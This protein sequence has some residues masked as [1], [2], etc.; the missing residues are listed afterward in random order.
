MASRKLVR[1]L[2]LSRQPLFL[3]L[4]SKQVIFQRKPLSLSP[5]FFVFLY[6]GSDCMF[7]FWR[8]R[9][10]AADYRW[11]Q[12]TGARIPATV[13]LASSMSFPRKLKE[14]LKC[15]Y[16]PFFFVSCGVVIIYLYICR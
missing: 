1:D 6:W 4:I 7:C 11:Y 12:I 5:P 10:Q 9:F 14:K 16:G 8:C 13:D 15:I 2:V 3:H